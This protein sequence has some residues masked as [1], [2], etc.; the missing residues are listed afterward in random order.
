MITGLLVENL[1]SF[2]LDG[3]SLALRPLSFIVRA[4]A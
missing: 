2:D 3:R 4:N 1:K